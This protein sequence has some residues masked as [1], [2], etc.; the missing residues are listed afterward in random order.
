MPTG[1][2]GGRTYEP[3]SGQMAPPTPRSWSPHHAIRGAQH[4]NTAVM[5][6]AA[7]T[8][9]VDTTALTG[10]TDQD[11]VLTEILA[12]HR[13]SPRYGTSPLLA[14]CPHESRTDTPTAMTYNRHRYPTRPAGHVARAAPQCDN[15]RTRLEGAELMSTSRRHLRRAHGRPGCCPLGNPDE[16][17]SNGGYRLQG[18]IGYRRTDRALRPGSPT[19]PGACPHRH[20]RR[21]RPLHLRDAHMSNPQQWTMCTA[22][23]IRYPVR[24]TPAY[25]Q[26]APRAPLTTQLYLHRRRNISRSNKRENEAIE[27]AVPGVPGATPP[28]TPSDLRIC[29]HHPP[30]RYAVQP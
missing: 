2:E 10:H 8:V 16:Q 4:S 5:V 24:E 18:A 14:I 30:T 17:R 27:W 15:G 13:P 28:E 21:H 6:H 12:R 11:S 20:R 1:V 3:H 7:N 22:H 29:P 25:G 26:F 19:R 23:P 9:P